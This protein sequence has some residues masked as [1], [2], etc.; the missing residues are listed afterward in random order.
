MDAA[1]LPPATDP[2]GVALIA[3]DPVTAVDLSH[4]PAGI[5]VAINAVGINSPAGQALLAAYPAP[6]PQ[7]PAAT[8]PPPVV[9]PSAPAASGPT[10]GFDAVASAPA[11]AAPTA[12]VVASGASL[13]E[14]LRANLGLAEKLRAN[15]GLTGAK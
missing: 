3:T 10:T 9:T 14:K 8:E 1:K 7:A 12:Q 4:I 5:L 13:A 11:A 15:L 6:Q 2:A